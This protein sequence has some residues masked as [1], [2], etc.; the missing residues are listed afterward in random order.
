M[1]EYEY[2]YNDRFEPRKNQILNSLHSK[3]DKGL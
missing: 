2:D 3:S 1:S